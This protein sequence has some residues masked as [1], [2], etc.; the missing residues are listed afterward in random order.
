MENLNKTL[1]KG[2]PMETNDT[3]AMVKLFTKSIPKMQYLREFTKN[4]LESKSSNITWNFEQKFLDERLYKLSITDTGIGL[5]GDDLLEYINKLSSSGKILNTKENFGIGAKISGLAYSPFGVEYYSWKNGQ[6]SYCKLKELSDG[7]YGL[8]DLG[9]G[10]FTKSIEISEAPTDIQKARQGTKVVFLG[11]KADSNTGVYETG[12]EMSKYLARRFFIL[13]TG[14]DLKVVEGPYE[15]N[16]YDIKHTQLREI[17]PQK[18]A[19]DNNSKFKGLVKFNGFN[20][21]WW[22]LNESVSN[23]NDSAQLCNNLT[24]H[25][26]L[27]YQDELYSIYSEGTS[28]NKLQDFGIKIGGKK[29]VLYLEVLS[30]SVTANPE[31]TGILLNGEELDF[32]YYGNK[33]SDNMPEE[34]KSYINE[35]AKKLA[36]DNSN[37][38]ENIDKLLKDLGLGTLKKDKEGNKYIEHSDVKSDDVDRESTKKRFSK[39]N[40]VEGKSGI[41]AS[42]SSFKIPTVFYCSSNPSNFRITKITDF[43]ELTELTPSEFDKAAKYI[44]GSNSLYINLD[45]RALEK[46]ITYVSTK[47]DEKDQNIIDLNKD[48]IIKAYSYQLVEVVVS[49]LLLSKTGKWSTEDSNHALSVDALTAAAMV[50]SS[51]IKQSIDDIKNMKKN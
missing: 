35:K 20:I 23:K 16:K 32:E 38:Q 39:N 26:G 19:L 41:K 10:I 3:S 46:I 34:I 5:T 1:V 27:L 2:L 18:I 31:R 4:S 7:R 43:S 36:D 51:V 22:I 8:E 40:G 21:H 13:P 37:W 48:Y 25:F 30:E 49:I 33:F 28:I 29:V 12:R 42:I 24:G 14:V 45:F 47:M 50:R 6:G 44:K 15:K 17:V 11:E 9:E